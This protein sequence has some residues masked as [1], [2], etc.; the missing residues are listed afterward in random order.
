MCLLLLQLCFLQ[1]L[2]LL[3]QPAAS[4]GAHKARCR[5]AAGCTACWQSTLAG[6]LLQMQAL[7]SWETT[8]NT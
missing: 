5:A 3:V 1:L 8:Y 4:T 6:C 7:H 2:L